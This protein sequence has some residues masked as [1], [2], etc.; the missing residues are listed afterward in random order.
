MPA[1]T[2]CASS[3]FCTSL[4]KGVECLG[5]ELMAVLCLQNFKYQMAYSDGSYLLPLVESVINQAVSRQTF[6]FTIFLHL[7]AWPTHNSLAVFLQEFKFRDIH[8]KEGKINKG[9]KNAY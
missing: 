2:T 7:Q 3:I 5:K 6:N 1:K 9:N 4:N 8:R